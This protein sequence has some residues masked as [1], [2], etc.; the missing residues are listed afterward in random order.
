MRVLAFESWLGPGDAAGVRVGL[1]QDDI[2]PNL[3][4]T[5]PWNSQIVRRPHQPQHLAG[6][7]NQNGLDVSLGDFH[8][9]I[10]D[11]SQPTSIADANDLFTLELC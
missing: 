7:G 4:D 9:H 2:R 8:L 5:V 1:Y 3:A 6:A 10:L 11:K